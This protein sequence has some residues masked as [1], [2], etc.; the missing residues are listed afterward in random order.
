MSDTG[1][2]PADAVFRPS[3]RRKLFRHRLHEEENDHIT[4]TI[5]PDTPEPQ[6]TTAPVDHEKT[7]LPEQASDAGALRFLHNRRGGS[8]KAG[9]GF[10]NHSKERND[11]KSDDRND[12][13]IARSDP[14]P[15]AVRVAASRFMVPTGQAAIKEDKHM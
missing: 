15:D 2:G 3:K 6:A 12:M 8:R 10:S 11:R 4:S 1:D 14:T 5:T 7:V 9:V 13:V